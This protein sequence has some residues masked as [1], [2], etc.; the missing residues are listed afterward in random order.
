MTLDLKKVLVAT[1][2]PNKFEEIK[3]YLAP[4]D[5]E[6]LS[7]NDVDLPEVQEIGTSF[8]DNAILKARATANALGI[9]SLSDDSG[10]CIKALGGQP[11]IFSARWA[12]REQNYMH[13]Y[14]KIESELTAINAQDDRRATFVCCLV[15]CFPDNPEPLIFEG[16]VEGT[17]TK[18]PRGASK[19]GYDPV[20]IPNGYKKTFA[21]M[22]AAEKQKISHRTEALKKFVT[23]L[24]R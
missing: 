16:Q 20:F 6:V 13:A 8:E 18:G 11:G 12:G 21:E 23:A 2:N 24:L 14:K 3:A 9:P 1:R 10:L 22:T 5:I 15:L 17:I 19:F 4:Y 7:G